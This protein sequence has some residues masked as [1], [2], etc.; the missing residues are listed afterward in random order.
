M[1]LLLGLLSLTALLAACP[2]RAGDFR[3]Q[4]VA[5]TD[6]RP[7]PL[8][9]GADGFYVKD[10]RLYFSAWRNDVGRELFSTDG[11]AAEATLVADLVPLSGSSSPYVLGAIGTA[12]I[13]SVKQ[14]E[15]DDYRYRVLA[16]DLPS[17]QTTQLAEFGP[18]LNFYVWRIDRVGEFAGRVAFTDL[19]Q[20]KVWTTDGSVAG[21]QLI[22]AQDPLDVPPSTRTACALPDRLLFLGAH[23]GQRQLWTSDG[24]PGGTQAVMTLDEPG[25]PVEVGTRSDGCY[26]LTQHNGGRALWLSNGSAAGTG[27]LHQWK[28]YWPYEVVMNGNDGYAL[29]SPSD[30]SLQLLRIGRSE[31]VVTFE[32]GDSQLVSTGQRLAFFGSDTYG[33]V[34]VQVSD[35]TAAGTRAATLD[36]AP[37]VLSGI[38]LRLVA[39]GGRF[40]ARTNTRL[41]AIDP[42][43]AVATDIGAVNVFGGYT[44]TATLGGIAI[45]IGRGADSG[46]EPW[47]SDGTVAGTRLLHDLARATADGI[48][49]W[50]PQVRGETVY[51]GNSVS[52]P[53][54]IR[55]QLWRTDGTAAGT[56]ALPAQHYAGDVSDL[57]LL[58]NDV[59]FTT[60]SGSAG[61]R[62]AYRTGADFGTTAL[63][64][65]SLA[66]RTIAASGDASAALFFC[67]SSGAVE[68]LCG[69]RSG[70]LQA[71]VLVPG[72]ALSLRRQHVGGI[73]PVA[74]SL[75]RGRLWRSDGSVPGS[76]ELMPGVAVANV[77]GD[78][79]WTLDGRLLF[80]ACTGANGRSCGV[81]V[82][83]GS[84]AGTLRIA[85]LQGRISAFAVLGNRALFVVGDGI[86]ELWSTDATTAGTLRLGQVG[87]TSAIAVA[88]NSAH[89]I[90]MGNSFRYVVSDGTVAGTRVVPM[91][92]QFD[93][94]YLTLSLDADTV[95]FAC[96]TVQAGAELCSV[97]AQGENFRVTDL[98][99]GQHGSLP[100]LL[101]RTPQT[102]YF[103]ADDGVHGNE[104]WRAAPN[105]ESIFADGFD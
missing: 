81:Y 39:D 3:A 23:A 62:R 72:G 84:A 20:G 67:S 47:R 50:R 105:G 68:N 60:E 78:S 98:W 63:L 11:T 10:G 69:L 24:T 90:G 52:T 59:V 92:A 75:Y 2:A 14:P 8:D 86:G 71:G 15:D 51:F 31:P 36:G 103:S 93:E 76:F 49:A 91:P 7:M 99:P 44:E 19:T 82:S 28:R 77:S 104:L 34:G 74:I 38:G 12:L 9:S 40:Y 58:G 70:D 18:R 97:D 6:P 94:P 79:A 21:T 64:W 57:A 46:G 41:Y 55:G 54:G 89:L 1:K 56:R 45:G 61:P 22:Y 80:S 83:D 95:L 88:G 32:F 101:A 96:S 85:E 33:A 16:L 66:D 87:V 53:D 27:R 30:G 26:F 43:T 4:L 35:G 37:L 29:L 17:G 73:G 100:R 48:W 5:D 13:V 42:A 25:F 65:D 102:V